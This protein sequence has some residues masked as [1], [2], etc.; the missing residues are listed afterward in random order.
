[1]AETAC[2]LFDESVSFDRITEET[3]NI[4]T[5][6]GWKDPDEIDTYL[7]EIQSNP[8]EKE[9]VKTA[10]AEKLSSTCGDFLSTAGMTAADFAESMV[11][12]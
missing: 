6:Y 8:E 4:M 2:L 3:N 1:M 5:S 12:Q 7:N 10:I 11:S 9:E